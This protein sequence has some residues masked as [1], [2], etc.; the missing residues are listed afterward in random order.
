VLRLAAPGGG[1][2]WSVRLA[3]RHREQTTAQQRQAGSQDDKETSGNAIN[4]THD[5]PP[6][7]KRDHADRLIKDVGIRPRPAALISE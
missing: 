7:W 5:G 6:V 3:E 4:A 2:F 1:A